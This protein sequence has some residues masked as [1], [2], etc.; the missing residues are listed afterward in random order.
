MFVVFDIFKSRTEEYFTLANLWHTRKIY[1]QG[2][3][4]YDTGYDV[5]R[6]SEALP[7][8]KRL[9]VLFPQTHFRHRGRGAAEAPLPG[10]ADDP[11]DDG[12][13]T[14]S[15]RTPRA[16]SR[17]SIPHGEGRR[18]RRRWRA[19]VSLVETAPERAGLA[20][21]IEAGVA[22][23]HR[24]RQAGPAHGHRPRLPAAA[25]RRSRRAGSPTARSRPT[26]TSC[27]PSEERGE[28][29]Y[30]IVNMTRAQYGEQVLFQNGP[31]VPRPAVRRHRPTRAASTR[32][33]TGATR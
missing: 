22:A 23:H 11:P 2:E 17:C 31:V 21:D 5:D 3:H 30:T 27:S 19:R 15:R 1:A 10:R 28:L 24:R 8:A 7:D 6:R 33:A 9:L 13:A 20:V 32:C 16:S 18:R 25:L 4:W 14:S 29:T 26:A 12:A